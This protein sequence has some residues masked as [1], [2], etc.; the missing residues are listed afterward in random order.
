MTSPQYSI[1]DSYFAKRS[2]H[3]LTV[4]MELKE[5]KKEMKKMMM[6]HP[7]WHAQGHVSWG[8]VI[9]LLAHFCML[10]HP[11]QWNISI[12]WKN[13]VGG[14]EEALTIIYPLHTFW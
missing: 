7:S 14:R 4:V 10:K 3:D 8:K 13:F 12:C 9:L 2:A 5:M 6:T 11:F 1:I